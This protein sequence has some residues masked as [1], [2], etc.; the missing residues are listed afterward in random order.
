MPS[1]VHCRRQADSIS[2]PASGNPPG[3]PV[4][5]QVLPALGSGGVERGTVDIAAAIVEAGGVSIV[6]ASGGRLV[7]ELEAIGAHHVDLP[8]HTKNPLGMMRNVA[9]LSRVIRE[10]SVDL[11]HAR[12]RAPAWSARLAAR[13]AGIP[14]LTTF[15]GRYGHRTALKRRY[16]AVMA[17]GHRV[18]AV[19]RFIADHVQSTYGVDPGRLRVIHRGT[20]I[21]RFDPDA[22]APSRV[23]RLRSDWGIGAGRRIVLLPG[24]LTAL[25]GQLLLIEA[26][27]RLGR[28]DLMAV[29]V[30]PAPASRY[31]RRLEG[32]LATLGLSE[33][34]RIAGDCDDMPAAYLAADVVVSVSTMPE[35]FGRVLTEAMAMR[36]P[37]IAFDH[38]AA[39][40]IVDHGRTGWLVPPLDVEALARGVAAALELGCDRRSLMG[41]AGRRSV[42]AE[43][44]MERMSTET[45]KVYEELLPCAFPARLQ[46]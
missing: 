31:R 15:H 25:K 13:R 18:I 1:L 3:R 36:R 35:S 34:A 44:S 43:F 7:S 39:P 26:L 5:L 6:A 20:D 4:I 9:R 46:E 30:G 11:V 23:A 28:P 33:H 12:S 37:V 17:S 27:A 22:V 45:L 32:R 21:A 38:G 40:E 42:R 8:M 24:R 10:H 14:F 2:R 29:L 41:E 19:S 16:N